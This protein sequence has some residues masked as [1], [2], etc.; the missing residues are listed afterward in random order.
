MVK[1]KRFVTVKRFEGEP[2]PSDLKLVEEELP[3][4]KEGE[5]LCKALWMSVDPYMRA[6]APRFP[7]GMTMMGSQVA[8]I[9]D[10]KN[11]E[12]KVGQH[13]VGHF[14]WQTISI[15][16]GNA[17]TLTGHDKPYIIPDFEGL[18]I[19]LALG[20]LGMPGNTAYFG[21]LELCQPKAGE[22]V[23]VTGAAGA[24]GSLVGQIARIRGCRVIG[25][26]GS[27]EKCR[28]LKEDLKFDSAFNYK[29]VTVAQALEEAAPDGVDCYFDNVGGETSSEIIRRMNTFGRIAVC[30]SISS[31]N[32]TNIPTATA[33]QM[34]FVSKQLKM[35]GFL[36]SRW[37]GRWNEGIL[38]NLKWIKEGKLKYRETITE[39][40]ERMPDAFISMLSGK[41]IGKAVVK[42]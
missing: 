12:F 29:K 36:V 24:V 4:L 41:N 13:V 30:G 21:L 5:F 6:Y 20:V 32:A 28:W 37:V 11:P 15:S 35:E 25:F 26:A 10:S 19:S 22:T 18:P 33:L 42:V 3:P 39:G 9:I 2:K 16:D 7:L 38:H 17:T 27:D 31:Y 14:G 8:E 23:V 1:T 34:P 40:F